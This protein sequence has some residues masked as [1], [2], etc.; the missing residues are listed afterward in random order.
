MRTEDMGSIPA[1]ARLSEVATAAG[2]SRSTVSRVLSGSPN[3]SPSA[4]RAV[5]EASHRLGYRPDPI[6]RAMRA[7]MTGCVGMIVP[8]IGNPFF[9][10]LVEAV[11]RA[12]QDAGMELILS[13]SQDS[14]ENEG[15]RVRSLV[16]RRIDGLV[17][18][19]VDHDASHGSLTHASHDMPVVQLD[20]QVDGFGGDYVG[21]DN[22]AG[23]RL[24]LDHLVDSGCTSTA[25]V[26]GDATTS[27]G[28][29]R[30]EAFE[31]ALRRLP[32][33]HAD[34]PVLGSFTFDFGREA[35]RE[36]LD[37]RPLPQAVV[38][39]S[40]IVALG[41]L[42]ELQSHGLSVPDDVLVT[43]FDGIAFHEL[44]SPSLTTVRQPVAA[45]AA[46]AVRL[47]QLR[48]SGDAEPPRRSQISP[49]LRVRSSSSSRVDA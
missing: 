17:I 33:V 10:E 38:C 43:G 47:L 42:R 34:R 13:D 49:T 29:S 5:T 12:L 7:G 9:A 22:M 46:E 44:A 39:G 26:S 20:R 45:L 19:P 1:K 25:F 2:V 14:P 31:S 36:L 6:A 24:V 35:A 30:L 18:I 32:H 27:A 48:L 37:R 15:N 40:D 16:A 3:V 8:G 11:E 4:V 41:V 28:R 21:V 23:I